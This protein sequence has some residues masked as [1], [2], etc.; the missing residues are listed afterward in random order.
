MKKP[1]QDATGHHSPR[2]CWA[3]KLCYGFDFKR[4]ALLE[5]LSWL[6]G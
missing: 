5:F 4:G 2:V 1:E 6:S 3:E